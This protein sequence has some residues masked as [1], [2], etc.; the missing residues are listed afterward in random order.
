MAQ[1]SSENQLRLGGA[2]VMV[3]IFGSVILYCRMAAL[4]DPAYVRRP[5]KHRATGQSVTA[6]LW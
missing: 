2:T 6:P 5:G 3:C 4:P 1:L